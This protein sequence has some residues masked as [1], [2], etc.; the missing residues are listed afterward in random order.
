[1]AAPL[2]TDQFEVGRHGTL[3]T[4]LITLGVIMMMLLV[5]CWRRTALLLVIFTVMIEL[6][7]SRGV[8]AVLANAGIIE[9]STYSTNLLT[10]LVIAAGTGYAIF[11]LG[12]Y[13]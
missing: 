7:A 11:I 8:V 9:L 10:L 12:R 5:L 3:K 1:G 2:V 6:T 4:T 13:T